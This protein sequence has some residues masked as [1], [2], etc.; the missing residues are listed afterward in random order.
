LKQ[1]AVFNHGTS[2]AQLRLACEK[3]GGV[4]YQGSVFQPFSNRGTFSKLLSVWQS[5]DTQ[6]SD[7]MRILTKRSKEW[8]EPR[9]KNTAPVSYLGHSN[10]M[11]LIR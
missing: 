7:N 3:L 4:R 5:L 8:A 10:N 1:T 9:L 6:N 2:H 11:T